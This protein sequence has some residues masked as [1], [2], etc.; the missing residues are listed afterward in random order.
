MT[1]DYLVHAKF[2]K[3][4]ISVV[5]QF[6]KPI[7]QKDLEWI[8]KRLSEEKGGK[9]IVVSFSPFPSTPLDNSDSEETCRVFLVRNVTNGQVLEFSLRSEAEEYYTMMVSSHGELFEYEF[10]ARIKHHVPSEILS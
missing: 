3:G 9:V 8:G 5:Y 6:K 2:L 10:V 4:D 1:Y 7:T